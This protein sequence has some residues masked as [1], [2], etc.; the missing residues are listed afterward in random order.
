MQETTLC[1]IENNER[2]LMLHR[3]KKKT[4]ANKGKW[5]GVGGKLETVETP[6]ECVLREIAEETGLNVS[7]LK[8][9]GV[10]KFVSDI[11]EDEIMHLFTSLSQTEDFTPCSEGE[12]KWVPKA[13]VLGLNLWEGDRVFLEYLLEDKKEFF[14]LSL[15][16][17]GESLKEVI[18]E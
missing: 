12:L 5:I 8:Y 14:N 3:T 15:I 11:Y 2:Y 4:D 7:E 18:K 17:K 16:Y 9:R 6:K 10:V 13:E 1:Y